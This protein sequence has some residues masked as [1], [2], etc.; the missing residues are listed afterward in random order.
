MRAIVKSASHSGVCARSRDTHL[1]KFSLPQVS[2][3]TSLGG[4][5]IIFRAETRKGF[6]SLSLF[7]YSNEAAAAHFYYS[8]ASRLPWDAPAALAVSNSHFTLGPHAS[9]LSRDFHFKSHT[10]SRSTTLLSTLHFLLGCSKSLVIQS[11]I[12]NVLTL[13][14]FFLSQ[15]F[16]S[17]ALE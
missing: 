5:R 9:V 6:F 17:L 4:G 2:P 12:C 11:R 8:R 3:S 1:A 15:M 10:Y 14:Y 7:A 13:L 16:Q